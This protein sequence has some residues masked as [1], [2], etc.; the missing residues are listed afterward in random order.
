MKQLVYDIKEMSDSKEIY[1]H[2]PSPIVAVFIYAI[3]GLLAAALMYCGFGKIEMVA[4]ASGVIRPNEEVG[5]VS[6]LRGGHVT[7]VNYYDGQV[8]Q[9]NDVLLTVDTT[10]LQLQL[11]SLQES[12]QDLTQQI[13]MINKFIEGIKA[14]ENPF[15]AEVSG[16]EYSYYIQF[17]S[18]LL[19][20]KNAQQTFDYDVN[21]TIS[22]IDALNSQ[23]EGLQLQIAGWKSYKVSIEQGKN[24]AAD[25]P[26]YEKM[27]LLYVAN[28]DALQSEYESQKEQ[29][30][31]S[32]AEEEKEELLSDLYNSYKASKE[33]ERYKTIIQIDSA[34]QSLQA[35]ISTAQANLKQNQIAKAFY[36][37]NTAQDGTPLSVSAGAIEQTATMLNQRES[38]QAQLN[39]I[40]TQIQQT[41]DQIA[42]GSIKAQ[43]DGTVCAVQ[44]LVTGDVISSGT[45]I[46]TILPKN[47]NVYKVQLYVNNADIANVQVGD[48][49]KFNIAALPSNQYGTVN[50]TVTKV[51]TDTMVQDGQYSG[52]YLVECMLE[53]N[54][55]SNQDGNTGTISTGMQVEGKIIT[56]EKT[57]LRYLLEKINIS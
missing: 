52:Y 12:Q 27:Y 33:Q 2:R 47:E 31:K 22:N 15:S 48:M 30:E 7:Q 14:K 45:V 53:R 40:E 3:L 54:T 5:T 55:L 19:Q 50:G 28:M 21:K 23:I 46:A 16:E 35:E 39:E 13:S 20:T 11:E 18:Y 24:L 49:V 9:K 38:V 43:C 8:V 34:I 32:G 10:D 36:D 56:Q 57:I 41:K 29:I 26:E 6:S 42:Q 17:E 44:T 1:G 37:E 4:T 25:Y 51:A